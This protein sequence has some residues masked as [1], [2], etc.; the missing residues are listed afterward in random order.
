MIRV[1]VL[2]SLLNVSFHASV[3][4]KEWRRLSI[5]YTVILI[6]CFALRSSYA[7]HAHNV[8]VGIFRQLKVFRIYY[9]EL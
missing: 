5:W 1:H 2:W 4:R 8:I 3:V 6:T 7:P 9:A